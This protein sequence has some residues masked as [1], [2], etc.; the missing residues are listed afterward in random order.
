MLPLQKTVLSLPTISELSFVHAHD[1][2]EVAITGVVQGV[3]FRPFVHRLA[4]RHG[5]SGWVRNEAGAVRVRAEGARNALDAF[6][7][8]LREELPPLARVDAFE[9]VEVE[10]DGLRAF[11]VIESETTASGRLPISPDVATCAACEA[12]LRDPTNPRYRYPFITCTDCGPRF[13]VIEAMP[14]DRVRTSMRAF[15]QCP[16]CLAEYEAPADRR[17]HSETNSCPV[18]GPSVW[19]ERVEASSLEKV[20]AGDAAIREAASVLVDG[21]IVAVRGLGGFHLAVRADDEVAVTRLRR[22]KARDSKPL[23]IMVGRLDAARRIAHVSGTQAEQLRTPARPIVV[24]RKRSDAELAP[25][26]SPGLDSVGVMLAYTPLHHLLLDAVDGIPLVMTSGNACDEPIAIGNAEARDR[27]SS[28]ADAFLLHDREIAARYDDSVMRV[29]ERGPVFLRRSRGY[30]PMPLRLPVPTHEPLLAVGPHLKNTFTLAHGADAYVSQH[31][32]DLDT[33]ETQAHFQDALGRFETLFR[34]EP[35]SVVRDMHPAY[36]STAIAEESGLRELPPVQHHHAHIAAVMAEHGVSS[37]VLGL[38]FDGTGYGTDGRVWGCEVMIA[39][40]VD[41]QRV[42]HLRYAPLPGGDRAVRA[43]WR[44]LLGYASLEDD[45]DWIRDALVDVRAAEVDVAIRQIAQ[46]VNAPMASSLGRLFDA[47]AAVLGIRI[48]SGHEGQAAMELEATAGDR[49]G[50][51]LPFPVRKRDGIRV[52]DPLPLLQGLAEGRR[53]GRSVSELAADFHETVAA[54]SAELAIDLCASAGLDK[55]ALGGGCFQ[56]I[57]LSDTLARSLSAGGLTVLEPRAL[58]PND[59]AVSY[60]Q[61]VVA[62]A[63]LENS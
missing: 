63:R 46:S 59:G 34:I 7:R 11:E 39:D 26:V 45:F 55:V 44:T 4:I 32:G 52:L 54:A 23:A 13:T 29:S 37:P 25:G 20:G 10:P 60:G 5:I 56:N 58:G 61:A 47:A 1:A 38:A 21:G 18:C 28:I 12:E 27:L 36:M 43:P 35:R 40:L 57:R 31:I 22:R 9:L 2:V 30:A 53:A 14:Y 24:L 3:G 48:E 19:L 16:S 17:Y 62:A 6:S 42:A 50:R 51:V 8:D 49:G 15:R 33:L 41:F